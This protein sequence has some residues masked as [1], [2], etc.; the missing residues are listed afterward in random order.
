MV[1]DCEIGNCGLGIG[2]QVLKHSPFIITHHEHRA[3]LMIQVN[4]IH[5]QIVC[6]ISIWVKEQFSESRKIFKNM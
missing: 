2:V 3:T 4:N 1:V 5:L 6:N